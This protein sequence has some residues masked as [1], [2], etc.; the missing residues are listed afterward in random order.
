MYKGCLQFVTWL[1]FIP[2]CV[3]SKQRRLSQEHETIVEVMTVVPTALQG[4]GDS[5]TSPGGKSAVLKHLRICFDG[6]SVSKINC[7][8]PQSSDVVIVVVSS[9]DTI[10]SA[11][12]H[13]KSAYHWRYFASSKAVAQA[14]EQMEASRLLEPC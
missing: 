11:M 14:P 3:I 5:R 10:T 6:S 8:C 7:C 9:R 12:A 4:F 13:T 1:F 2:A